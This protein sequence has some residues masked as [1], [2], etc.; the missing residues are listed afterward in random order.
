[1]NFLLSPDYHSPV[2]IGRGVT[3]AYI[4]SPENF[5]F[6]EKIHNA[7]KALEA[8]HDIVVYEGTG[9]PGVGSVCDLS[10]A[11]VAKMLNAPVIMIVE[12]GIGNTLDRLNTNLALLKQWPIH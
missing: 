12:G 8:I 7:S 2:I 5:N 1:M 4:E 10:N 3:K 6:K 9:H 11:D